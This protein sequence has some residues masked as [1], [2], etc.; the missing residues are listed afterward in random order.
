MIGGPSMQISCNDH[1]AVRKEEEDLI[2]NL[3]LPDKGNVL[4][5]G[6]G[7]GRH[8]KY[9]RQIR[10]AVHCFGIEICDLMLEH[11]KETITS[12]ATFVKTFDELS[13][14][15]FDL[16][17]FMGNGLGV[18]GDEQNTKATLKTMV[19]SLSP[20][21]YIVIETGNP[22]G[23]SFTSASFKIEYNGNCDGP[24]IWN[25]SDRN[26]ISDQLCENGCRVEVKHSN[27]PGNMF[28]FAIG[29]K[30]E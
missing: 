10:P 28:F 13:N 15:Q 26:W 7:V 30:G 12:P 6:C 18:L 23:Q 1:L 14:K 8:L 25:Y 9:V 21:G 16:I 29:Q 5:W 20:T 3:N 4:D 2:D 19:E 11:C 22:F 24:F 27:A 17:M